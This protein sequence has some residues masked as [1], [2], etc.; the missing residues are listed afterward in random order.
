[1]KTS[2]EGSFLKSL[3]VA[4]GDGLAFGVGMKLTQKAQG[5]EARSA[6]L[7][8]VGQQI[9]EL[10]TRL[11]SLERL[12]ATIAGVQPGARDEAWERGIEERLWEQAGT[13]ARRLAALEE[14]VA[15]EA[16]KPDGR[17]AL[18][19]AAESRAGELRAELREQ[20]GVLRQEVRET[21][22]ALER[23][24][25][26]GA[27][28]SRVPV[29]A[30]H[31]SREAEQEMAS[32]RS[33]VAALREELSASDAKKVASMAGMLAAASR[34]LSLVERQVLEL[35]AEFATAQTNRSDAVENLRTRL[36]VETGHLKTEI[37]SLREQLT[38]EFRQEIRGVHVQIAQAL[39]N[40]GALEETVAQHVN[41][42]V[43]THLHSM[44][45]R[46]VAELREAAAGIADVVVQSAEQSISRRIA[47]LEAALQDKEADLQRLR[48]Q[49]AQSEL[50]MAELLAAVGR[51]CAQAAE[52]M[53]TPGRAHSRGPA[54]AAGPG[55][56][57]DVDAGDEP[58][59]DC[60]NGQ[61]ALVS[62]PK[63]PGK[64]W[65]IPVVS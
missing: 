15:Q 4:F 20:I 49:S 6:D 28:S 51:I 37:S 42:A 60:R 11:A 24:I 47:P 53:G 32:L 16:A 39:A 30:A 33:A 64:V 52:R 40:S 31:L 36:S 5:Q 57:V 48:E 56:A 17:E 1:M 10:E 46:M 27:A 35:Q 18:A 65:R 12:P 63:K 44:Q 26:A 29:T 62:Y 7:A 2:E 3:A 59:A 41:D 61:P 21:V 8:A 55:Q 9:G 14:R 58:D 25:A 13:V 45:R 22:S 50:A 19:A 23:S 43:E 38:S 34:D 54:S